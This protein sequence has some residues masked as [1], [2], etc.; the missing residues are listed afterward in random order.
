MKLYRLHEFLVIAALQICP[1]EL[2]IL[3]N[4][5]CD[6]CENLTR[7]VCTMSAKSFLDVSGPKNMNYNYVAKSCLTY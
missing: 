6:L 7:F 2:K 5:K 3:D 1:C 4:E